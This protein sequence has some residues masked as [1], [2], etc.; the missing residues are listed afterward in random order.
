[1]GGHVHIHMFI[2]MHIVSNAMVLNVACCMTLV[3]CVYCVV[4]SCVLCRA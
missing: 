2:Y 4:L 1:M 3:V